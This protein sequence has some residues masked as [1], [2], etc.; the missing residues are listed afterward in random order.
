MDRIQPPVARPHRGPHVRSAH[1]LFPPFG[2]MFR[3]PPL[4]LR[5]PPP[6]H[7]T[8]AALL[9]P[10]R[11]S[12]S[13]SPPA[14]HPRLYPPVASQA[15]HVFTS[16]HPPAPTS[17]LTR[18]SLRPLC[19]PTRSPP[20][21]HYS[22]YRFQSLTPPPPLLLLPPPPMRSPPS[23]LPHHATSPV[24]H[25]LHLLH[26]CLS[27]PRHPAA[28]ATRACRFVLRIARFC[29]F[30]VAVFASWFFFPQFCSSIA[31]VAFLVVVLFAP[32]GCRL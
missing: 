10:R 24:G 25:S 21:M 19:P 22:R 15:F 23:L 18:P 16:A 26:T 27:L 13:L 28:E 8:T 29:P 7:L 11:L 3:A 32:A 14:F 6:L 17:A 4:S 2:S 31:F 9:L 12:L 30:S 1:P 5:M 20:D